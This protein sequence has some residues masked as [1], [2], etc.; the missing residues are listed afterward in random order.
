MESRPRGLAHRPAQPLR[1]RLAQRR[2]NAARQDMQR[3][4]APPHLAGPR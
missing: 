2:R 1:A 4:L 3:P